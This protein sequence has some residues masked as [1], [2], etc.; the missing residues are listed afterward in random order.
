MTGFVMSIFAVIGFA[1]SLLFIG[2]GI[3]IGVAIGL[4]LVM[5]FSGDGRTVL[6]TWAR[7]RAEGSN[8]D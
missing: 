1:F 4:E 8:N 5:R 3:G 6:L 2:A 7:T